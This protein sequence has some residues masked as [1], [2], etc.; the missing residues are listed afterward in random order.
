MEG[1]YLELDSPKTFEAVC[2]AALHVD[3][4]L[5]LRVKYHPV[6]LGAT[7]RR[8]SDIRPSSSSGLA[9][10]EIVGKPAHKQNKLKAE[11]VRPTT[12]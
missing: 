4:P 1:N 2:S 3:E 11:E 12:I 5:R 7:S 6:E 8:N 9:A 10:K